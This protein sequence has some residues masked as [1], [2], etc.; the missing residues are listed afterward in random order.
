MTKENTNTP[1][2]DAFRTLLV[3]CPTLAIPLVNEVFQEKYE[4]WDKADVF[5]A[6]LYPEGVY[7]LDIVFFVVPKRA[8]YH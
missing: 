3:K 4:L 7:Q 1:Y 8:D 6:V 2:D 5:H